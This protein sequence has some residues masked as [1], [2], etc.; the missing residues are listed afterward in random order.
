[1]LA[2]QGVGG[3][4]LTAVTPVAAATYAL[5]EAFPNHSDVSPLSIARFERRVEPL[6]NVRLTAQPDTNEVLVPSHR[7][8]DS[9]RHLISLD[10]HPPSL[11]L[12]AIHPDQRVFFDAETSFDAQRKA[13]AQGCAP[14]ILAVD[15]K[16]AASVSV[17]LDGWTTAR[18]SDLKRPDL[19]NAVIRA[20]RRIHA[21]PRFKST[22]SVF[23]RIRMLI[24]RCNP[25]VLDA[26]GDLRLLLDTAFQIERMITAAGLDAVP[27]H[28]DGFA[29][30][31]LLGPTGRIQLVDFDEARNVD[32]HF[33]FALLANEACEDETEVLLAL[34]MFEGCPRRGS[35]H[36]TRLY[37][38]VDD[39]SWALWGLFMDATSPR[40]EVE[41]YR[42]SCWRL[43]RCRSAL[44]SIDLRYYARS[45]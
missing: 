27:A 30:N 8:V 35:I 21:G 37:C 12:K 24:S 29:S 6:N 16:R 1:M 23:D 45:L 5:R 22:W 15:L 34:E 42:Y 43:L 44:S 2:R 18:V 4:D 36:R 25:A 32:P 39:L 17:Y 13:A 3:L 38:I 19:M 11:L 14:E 40:R 33:E 7:G 41:F 31:I 28:A 10:G 20:K 26:V 9:A